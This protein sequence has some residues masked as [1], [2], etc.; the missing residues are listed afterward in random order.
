MSVSSLL[1]PILILLCAFVLSA[2]DQDPFHQ[3]TR[4]IAAHYYLLRWE[5]G[6]TY[7]LTDTQSLE[8]KELG[9][10]VIQGTVQKIGWSATQIVVKRAAMVRNEGDGWMIIDLKDR[11]I[12]GPLTD[13]EV[14]KTPGVKELQMLDPSEAWR[15]LN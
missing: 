8:E 11:K 3:N 6:Q 10:G 14:Q 9:G 5:D 7:Y 2:C 4:E 15:R 13:A 1:R 12:L